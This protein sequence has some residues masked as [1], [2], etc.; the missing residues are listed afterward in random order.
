V[1]RSQGK[2]KVD[3][4][5]RV[6]LLATGLVTKVYVV[7]RCAT[8]KVGNAQC[9]SKRR[10]VVRYTSPLE[11]R[12]LCV[13]SSPCWFGHCSHKQS[14]AYLVTVAVTAAVR[15]SRCA[16]AVQSTASSLAA[17]CRISPAADGMHGT[18]SCQHAVEGVISYSM[19]CT[20]RAR[21]EQHPL[22]HVTA[23]NCAARLRVS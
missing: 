8:A 12:S 19:A 18:L 11:H 9:Y 3:R 5:R 1:D 17:P 2:Y 16:A 21:R 14:L 22:I 4:R 13:P 23:Q 7:T 20:R 15:G 6:S 10:S